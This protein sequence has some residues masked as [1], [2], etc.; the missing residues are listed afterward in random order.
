MKRPLLV[1]NADVVDMQGNIVHEYLL[2]GKRNS[3]YTRLLILKEARAA[4]AVEVSPAVV[5][6]SRLACVS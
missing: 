4:E 5:M 2:S 1:D 3:N 6:K